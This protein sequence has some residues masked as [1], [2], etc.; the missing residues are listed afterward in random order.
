MRSVESIHYTWTVSTALSRRERKREQTRLALIRSALTLFRK[1][2][3][4]ATTVE[5]IAEAADYHRATFFRV[6]GS[7]DDVAL[8]DISE[9]LEAARA[10]L[11][12]NTHSEDPWKTACEIVAREGTKFVAGDPQLQASY[13]ALWISDP[14][15]QQRFTALMIEWERA[16]AR[17]FATCWGVDPDHDIDCQVIGTAIIGVARSSMLVS[18]ASEQSIPDLLAAGFDTLAKGI[19]RTIASRTDDR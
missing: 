4:E 12:E 6:F 2:G 14:G 15:L 13:V 17:F 8:G 18:Q 5:E 9:R 16:V 3:F 1:Q 19:S 10:A 7:K 11:E